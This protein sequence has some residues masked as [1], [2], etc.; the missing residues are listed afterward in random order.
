MIWNIGKNGLYYN[1]NE[2]QL[3]V[4]E[5]MNTSHLRRTSYWG[6]IWWL[7]VSLKFKNLLWRMRHGCLPTGVR[8]ADKGVQCHTNCV[9][10]DCS[11][12][13]LAY[14]C[15]KLSFFDSDLE[16]DWHLGRYSSSLS[17]N[18]DN[19]WCLILA[20]TT[21]GYHYVEFMEASESQIMARCIKNK[22]TCH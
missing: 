9:S 21:F 18:Y 7:K 2:Y 3:Y 5:L 12:E 8:L 19:I 17:Q 10:Y 11:H 15:F 1:K 22:W 4:E 6:G 16:V 20:F 13:D 14:V